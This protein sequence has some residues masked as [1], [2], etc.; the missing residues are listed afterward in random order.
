MAHH[1]LAKATRRTALSVALGLCFA[2]GAYAQAPVGSVSG[3]AGSGDTIVIEN[4]ATGFRREIGADANGNFRVSSLAPGNY[5]VTA[6]RAD[7]TTQTRDVVVSI[8]TG[9]SVSFAPTSAD[10]TRLEAIE[11][12]GTA[13][14][15][16]DVSSVESTTVLSADRIAKIPVPRD[17]TNV[18]LLAPG[19]TRGD[20]A[21]GNLASFGGAS[22]AENG[23]FVNGFNV[24]NSF[25]GLNF[26]D[27]PFEA[28][29][30]QQ[31]KTGG[32][33]AEFGRVLGGVVN[34][35]TKRGTNEF[36]A[37]GNIFYTPDALRSH[38][39]DIFFN[40]GQHVDDNSRDGGWEAI[41]SAWV[42]GPLIRD[43]LF[44]YALLQYER[45][46]VEGKPEPFTEATNDRTRTIKSPTWLLK[47]D[48]NITDNHLLE[49][50]GFSDKQE[51]DDDR[52]LYVDVSERGPYLGTEFIE[53]GG[54]NY[55]LK[56]TGYL[57]DT[58]TLSALYGYGKFKRSNSA[59]SAAGIREEYFGDI[60]GEVPGCPTV[61][62]TRPGVP[63]SELLTG[64]D[65]AGLL[66]RADA[67]D[68]RNQFRVDAEW[69]I[70]DH[71]LRGGIDTDK[72]KTVDGEAAEGG[73]QYTYRVSR[74][75]EQVRRTF[76]RNG[77]TV[78][79]D[80]RAFY[81][82]DNWNVT[83]DLLLYAGLRWDKF[84]NKNGAGETY[85]EQDDQFGPRLGFSWDVNGDS[86]LKVFGNA[87]RYALP[88]AST[89]A[90]RG[91]SASRFESQDFFFTGV[92]TDGT[93]APLGLTEI[94]LNDPNCNGNV[95]AE[96]TP[97]VW[98]CTPT[99]LNNEF[100]AGKAAQSIASENLDPQ[101]QDEFI[102]GFQK[103]I[104]D[105]F[106]LG[107]RGIYRELKRG[108][109]DQCDY[110]PVYEWALEN[111]FVDP[112]GNPFES[113][114]VSTDPNEIAMINPGFP[115]CRLY[116]P[117]SDGIFN[118]DING[119]GTF[120]KVRIPADV[121]GPKAKRNYLAVEVFFEGNWDKFFLQGS[122]TWS[123]SYGNYEGG[124]KSD[125][126]QDDT[127]VTQDFDYPELTLGS[128]GYLPN[129]RRHAIKIFG[130]Y[131]FTEEWS[132]GANL[133]IQS[134]R[135]INCFG[136]YDADPTGYG[137]SYFSCSRNPDPLGL[138]TTIVTRGSAGR[139]PWIYTVDLNAAYRPAWAEGLTFKLDVF[140]AFDGHRA[141]ALDEFGEDGANNPLFDTSYMTPTVFQNPR[142]VRF[143]VQYEF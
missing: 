22:V 92:A 18:A 134:G 93:D 7:G 61:T 76:F 140:N 73:V 117:G 2:S 10:A 123:K 13:I 55:V 101:Y 86:S 98:R 72:Y 130:N 78:E 128:N 94:D 8:G 52:F 47:L 80:S 39:P 34:I 30:E 59:V 141:L 56:Y 26:A 65:F 132:V 125:I 15:P 121:L 31:I 5:R 104:T 97:G 16:I 12:R 142:T 9:A 127:G 87:G 135:P 106:S 99:F 115:F 41:A 32:Y 81:L 131:E 96:G 51:F 20:A 57:T 74:G 11:V 110:R 116:N 102:L 68:T 60:F 83:D 44:G 108:I 120:E 1:R 112:D 21:F 33:G 84:E 45:E 40:D 139:T 124:V 25:K 118:M 63:V 29:G 90:I 38:D 37:G 69:Q 114:D 111:G 24:T 66:T 95:D 70:G 126:G 3:R 109:D 107:A 36:R 62:D 19:T 23:Y 100:G 28:I 89:V 67:Q 136:V 82:E 54:E 122:Y 49:F 17:I 4:P 129:D 79:V 75:V 46:E 64:C 53:Q 50:T 103:A 88:I 105:E 43:K 71:L 14:N 27:V 48:W 91:A 42:S 113:P 85:V 58:F 143:M 133:L 6:R 137:A 77:A 35:V 119:D 138:D